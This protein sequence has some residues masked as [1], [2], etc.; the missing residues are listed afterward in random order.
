MKKLIFLSILS[1]FFFIQE[2]IAQKKNVNTNSDFIN[3]EKFYIT[4]NSASCLISYN[5]VSDSVLCVI[6][7]SKNKDF[8]NQT[9]FSSEG[10]WLLKNANGELHIRQ[11]SL[12]KLTPGNYYARILWIDLKCPPVYSAPLLASFK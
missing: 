3:L 2:T 8:S 6:E 7:I 9:L 1:I 10:K 11:N 5:I 12:K 4:E